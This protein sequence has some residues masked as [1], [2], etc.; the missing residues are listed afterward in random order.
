VPKK[1]SR[2][3]LDIEDESLVALMKTVQKIAKAVREATNAEGINIAMNNEPA[4]GQVIFH[5]HVHVIPRF[6][7]DGLS[8]WPARKNDPSENVIIAGKIRAALA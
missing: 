4:A 5:T 2:N 6:L 8:P 1:Y 3:I 7:E